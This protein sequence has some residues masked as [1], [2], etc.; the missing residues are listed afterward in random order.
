[1][2]ENQ[3]MDYIEFLADYPRYRNIIMIILCV[4]KQLKS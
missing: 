3:Y 1:M 2:T 4:T